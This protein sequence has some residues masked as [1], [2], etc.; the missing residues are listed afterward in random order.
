MRQE[1][2]CNIEI[3]TAMRR[4]VHKLGEGENTRGMDESKKLQKIDKSND[5]ERSERE[6]KIRV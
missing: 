4:R 1:I 6:R 5:R 2:K 3:T